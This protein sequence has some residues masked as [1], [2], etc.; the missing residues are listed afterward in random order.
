MRNHS[1]YEVRAL[2]RELYLANVEERRNAYNE[3]KL[4][5]IAD[6]CLLEAEVFFLTFEKWYPMNTI[7]TEG[8]GGRSSLP[9]AGSVDAPDPSSAMDTLGKTSDAPQ[10]VPEP[11]ETKPVEIIDDETPF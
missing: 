10:G 11:K 6:N 1:P 3:D 2:A 9:P 4:Q 7:T 5:V 8:S